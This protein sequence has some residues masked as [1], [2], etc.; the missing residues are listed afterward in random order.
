MVTIKPEVIAIT[1]TLHKLLIK[2]AASLA[3]YTKQPW[4]SHVD[5]WKLAWQPFILSASYWHIMKLWDSYITVNEIHRAWFPQSYFQC[6]PFILWFGAS[7]LSHVLMR[8]DTW[9]SENETE[10]LWIRKP[11][12]KF[13]GN[14]CT[15]LFIYFK[16]LYP[17]PQQKI[18]AASNMI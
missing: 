4:S 12:R 6:S 18:V 16:H 17:A 9:M 8:M 2:K 15:Y 13:E 7:I 11:I 10:V 14:E 5:L 3:I 1:M